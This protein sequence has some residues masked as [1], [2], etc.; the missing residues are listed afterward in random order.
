[1]PSRAAT[2]SMASGVAWNPARRVRPTV[3]R[4]QG[5]GA[6]GEDIAQPHRGEGGRGAGDDPESP[7]RVTA[8]GF[9]AAGQVLGGLDLPSVL[10]QE[11][12]YHLATMGALVAAFL[13]GH[14]DGRVPQRST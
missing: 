6:V 10:V 12:G 14:A 11:G 13:A 7:L 1:V 8:D 2:V 4:D 9:R 3:P 5:R